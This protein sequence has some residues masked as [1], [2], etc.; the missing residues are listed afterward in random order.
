MHAYGH[1]YVAV[2][3]SSNRDFVHIV[4]SCIRVPYVNG[5]TTYSFDSTSNRFVETD[6]RNMAART[7]VRWYCN[8]DNWSMVK[9][10]NA[11]TDYSGGDYW[12]SVDEVRNKVEYGLYCTCTHDTNYEK[13]GFCT[14]CGAWKKYTYTL[15][16]NDAK[17][18]DV[19]FGAWKHID[20]SKARLNQP[21]TETGGGNT[22]VDIPKGAYVIVYAA[23]KNGLGNLV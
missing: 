9:G 14:L 11:R 2:E 1:F 8:S 5:V 10:N 20:D 15:K 19:K 3:L 4:D 18:T 21:Y 12:V 22:A 7:D 16:N 23:V 6:V 13:S 17:K